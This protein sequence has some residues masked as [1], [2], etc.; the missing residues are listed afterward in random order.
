[1]DGLEIRFG[2]SVEMRRE[3]NFKDN[4]MTKGIEE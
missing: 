3:T 1:M 2:V 4:V